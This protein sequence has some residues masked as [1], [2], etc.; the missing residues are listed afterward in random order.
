MRRLAGIAAVA[1]IAAGAFASGL[2]LTRGENGVA[3]TLHLGPGDSPTLLIDQVRQ[4]LIAG[5]YTPIST[6]TLE[7]RSIDRSSTSSTT[8]TR[9]T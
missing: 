7:Q 8:R 1:L 2:V 6:R 9:T 3:E 5:Y 4:E